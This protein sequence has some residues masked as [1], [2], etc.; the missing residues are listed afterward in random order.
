[1]TIGSGL[2]FQSAGFS[3]EKVKLVMQTNS[4]R[5][6]AARKPNRMAEKRILHPISNEA[7]NLARQAKD[8]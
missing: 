6:E 8:S 1:V 5:R 2:P 3:G 4:I 7:R